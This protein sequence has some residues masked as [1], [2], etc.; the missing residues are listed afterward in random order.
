MEVTSLPQAKLKCNS[1]LFLLLQLAPSMHLVPRIWLL[2]RDR[3][4]LCMEVG[5]DGEELGT[6]EKD[7]K[8]EFGIFSALG[9]RKV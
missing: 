8:S 7:E 3:V 2:V 4:R 5:V 6:E 1:G 9:G